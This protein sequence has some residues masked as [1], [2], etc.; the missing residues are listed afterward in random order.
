M[1]KR[2]IMRS[3]PGPTR[4]IGQSS[5]HVITVYPADCQPRQNHLNVSTPLPFVEPFGHL[6]TAQP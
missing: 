3:T 4:L 6:R 5:P 1:R 2:K